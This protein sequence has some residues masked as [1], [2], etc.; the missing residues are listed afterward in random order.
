MIYFECSQTIPTVG[1]PVLKQIVK[2]HFLITNP[3]NILSLLP[4][5]N[6]E[7]ITCFILH[8]K[9]MIKYLCK[10]KCQVFKTMS[11]GTSKK[12]T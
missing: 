7:N 5:L 6:I 4:L 10:T 9:Q 11:S 1:V 8:Q 2:V 12:Q 3:C